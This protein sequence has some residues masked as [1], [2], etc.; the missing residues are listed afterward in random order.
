MREAGRIVARAHQAMREAVKPG[1]TTAQLNQIA[2]D[3]IR[4]SNA[5]PTFMGYPPGSR[6]PF[7]ATINASVNDELVHKVVYPEIP[8]GVLLT[9]T[10]AEV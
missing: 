1:V 5:I 9:V 10:D 2:E 3:L 6:Y 8:A 7:P 4:K